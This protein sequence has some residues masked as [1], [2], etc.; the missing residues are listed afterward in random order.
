MG[1]TSDIQAQLANLR[2][3]MAKTIASSSGSDQ[4]KTR[5]ITEDV[6]NEIRDEIKREID[7]L[8]LLL[9]DE[10]KREVE[11]LRLMSEHS[12]VRAGFLAVAASECAA[13]EK[14][15]LFGKLKAREEA[16]SAN[17]NFKKD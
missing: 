4:E 11:S 1:D 3:T 15:W 16:L 12:A 13:E 2:A 5:R 9:R 7:S 14:A 6:R 10:M 17:P 8:T